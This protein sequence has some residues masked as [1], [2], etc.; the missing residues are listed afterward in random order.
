MQNQ[1]ILLYYIILLHIMWHCSLVFPQNYNTCVTHGYVH[2]DIITTFLWSPI[3]T[4]SLKSHEYN[5]KL[6]KHSH[7]ALFTAPFVNSQ[8]VNRKKHLHIFSNAFNSE[9]ERLYFYWSTVLTKNLSAKSD[10]RLV[11][12]VHLNISIFQC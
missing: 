6:C 1:C 3:P 5:I 11:L 10:E 2:L 12:F 7:S 8:T 9:I 4:S